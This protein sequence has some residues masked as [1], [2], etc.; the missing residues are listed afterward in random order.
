MHRYG[1]GAPMSRLSRTSLT[2]LGTV[3]LLFVGVVAISYQAQRSAPG[4]GASNR[5]NA[6]YSLLET[7]TQTV[8]QVASP[9][10]VYGGLAALAFV[11]LGLVAAAG[12]AN[13]R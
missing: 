8:G 4:A 3:G 10:L 2:I 6:T 12:G 11:V 13:G 1:T 9:A 5:T 7:A